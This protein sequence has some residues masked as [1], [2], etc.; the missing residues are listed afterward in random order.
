MDTMR[1]DGSSPQQQR[2]KKV[3]K[4][5]DVKQP[6]WR[7]TTLVTDR[8]IQFATAKT[9]VFCDSVLRLR[10]ISTE[11]VKASKNRINWFLET[12][13]LKDLDRIDGEP[14]EFEWTNFHRIH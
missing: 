1:A 2:V 12:R 7:E 8:T 13:H 4:E 6:M 3:S 14:M 10:G 5:Q 9:Y 11:P